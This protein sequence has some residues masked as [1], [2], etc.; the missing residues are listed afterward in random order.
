[1]LRR[2]AQDTAL[3]PKTSVTLLG[4]PIRLDIGDTSGTLVVVSQSL[5]GAC[6]KECK[7]RLNPVLLVF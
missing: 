2:S 1:M 4:F 7:N 5:S 6:L 3:E